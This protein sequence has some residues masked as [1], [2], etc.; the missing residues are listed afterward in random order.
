MAGYYSMKNAKTHS[1]SWV[2]YERDKMRRTAHFDNNYSGL[3]DWSFA[4]LDDGVGGN[5]VH[6]D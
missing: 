5:S 3:V 6:R 1:R 4:L 2:G